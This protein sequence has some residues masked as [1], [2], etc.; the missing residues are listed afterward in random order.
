MLMPLDLDWAREYLEDQLARKSFGRRTHL[1]IKLTL[2]ALNRLSMQVGTDLEIL[3]A[4]IEDR[5]RICAKLRERAV[6][7]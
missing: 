1:A 3:D 4:V 6:G 2:I 5:N 7:G